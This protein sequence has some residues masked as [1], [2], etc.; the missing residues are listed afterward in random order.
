MCT[1][2]LFLLQS[3]KASQ[4]EIYRFT[5]SLLLSFSNSAL[6]ICVISILA[7]N[8]SWTHTAKNI[9]AVD[10]QLNNS[11]TRTGL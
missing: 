6:L 3:M 2:Y 5:A 10:I 9:T 1:R 7:T 8:F 11:Y 4:E